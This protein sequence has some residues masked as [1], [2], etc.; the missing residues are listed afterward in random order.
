MVGE[1][2]SSDSPKCPRMEWDGILRGGMKEGWT[3][4]GRKRLLL[5]LVPATEAAA[6]KGAIH[7]SPFQDDRQTVSQKRPLLSRGSPR[8]GGGGRKDIASSD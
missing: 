7:S 5:L 6:V 8:E 4:W 3:I 1:R 2:G